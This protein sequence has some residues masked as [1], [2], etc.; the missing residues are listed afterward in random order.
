MVC[1]YTHDSLRS[2]Y[3]GVGA[4]QEERNSMGYTPF[5]VALARGHIT[6]LR[7]VID[8]HPPEDTEALYVQPSSK[9]NL[10]LALESQ[11]PEAVWVVLDNKLSTA[12]ETEEVWAHIT[13][14]TG[15]QQ[16]LDIANVQKT[17]DKLGEIINLLATF[18]NFRLDSPLEDTNNMNEGSR[19]SS[20]PHCS[21]PVSEQVDFAPESEKRSRRGKPN[22]HPHITH[23]PPTFTT[24]SSQ[25]EPAAKITKLGA[26]YAE[27]PR[28]ERGKGS[29]GSRGRG[30]FRGRGRNNAPFS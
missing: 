25:P 30:G 8:T 7:Y 15:R 11:V 19:S 5:H 13:S 16:F 28:R 20:P 18:G 23:R 2:A 24:N 14:A 29:R 21:P 6:I 3:L 17:G 9:S 10:Q 1:T 27:P 12:A 4:D 26:D 22:R